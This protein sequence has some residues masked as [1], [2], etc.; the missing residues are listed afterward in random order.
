PKDSLQVLVRASYSDGAV[1]DVTRWAKLSSSE[2][3]VAGVDPGGR[4]RV[5]APGEAAVSAWF[6]NL[7][8]VNRVLVPFPGRVSPLAFRSAARHNFIDEHVL[9]KLQALNLPPSPLCDDREFIRRAYLDTA[10]ILPT[11]EEVQKF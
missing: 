8:A 10:G 7:V 4:V 11:P 1:E 6:S 3:L 2:E 5:L 9:A